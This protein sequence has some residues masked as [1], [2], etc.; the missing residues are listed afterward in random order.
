MHYD[1]LVLGSGPAGYYSALS[2]ARL[3]RKTLLVER[4][5]LGGT[6]FRWGCLPVKMM[7]DRLRAPVGADDDPH[8]SRHIAA[9]SPASV[10]AETVRRI[11]GVESRIEERL[12]ASGVEVVRG[13]GRFANPETFLLG[14]RSISASRIVIATGTEPAG[15]PGIPI[16]GRT[17]ISHKEVMELAEVPEHL[18]ILGGDVEGIEFACLFAHLGGR[19]TVVEKEPRILPGTDADLVEPI[20]RDLRNRG[21]S[22]VTGAAARGSSFTEDGISRITQ[23]A[24]HRPNT[25]VT[26]EMEDGSRLVG[27]RVLVTG[28]RQPNFPEGLEKA[29]VDHDGQKIGVNANLQT[30]CPSIYAVGDINGITGMAHAA[31]RQAL[32]AAHIIAGRGGGTSSG[33]GGGDTHGGDEGNAS[34]TSHTAHAGSP[35]PRAVYTLPEIAGAGYQELELESKGIPYRRRAYRLGDTWRGF[36]KAIPEGF[37]KV[38]AGADERILGIWICGPDASEQAALFGPLLACGLS[39]D[40]LR[41]GQILHPTLGEA[42]LEATL[43]FNGI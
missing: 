29:G 5:R 14:R 36:S 37:V 19:V 39:I 27:D 23:G 34:R 3:G 41:N 40:G 9:G 18:I 24:V 20:E 10:I 30:S 4:D 17:V 12:T 43:D 28:L 21:V 6:G 1:V 22:L 16:D 13:K 15:W 31:I 35:Y 8:D 11:E 33:K 32:Q 7:L 25:V 42:I 38:L 2:C 26:V